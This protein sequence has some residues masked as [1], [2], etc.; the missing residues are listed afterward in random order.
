MLSVQ[1]QEYKKNRLKGMNK[2]R[3]ALAA[4]YSVKYANHKSY[5]LDKVVNMAAAFHRKGIDDD[6]LVDFALAGLEAKKRY[7]KD[8]EFEDKDWAVIHKFFESICKLTG[9]LNDKAIDIDLSKHEHFSVMIKY[10]EPRQNATQQISE[11]I[12]TDGEA[13]TSPRILDIS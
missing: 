4:G 12:R 7:G 5:R 13:G 11:A 8:G 6:S 10:P 2:V 3:A 9:R 1:Q